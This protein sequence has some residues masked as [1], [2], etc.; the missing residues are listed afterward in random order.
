[1]IRRMSFGFDNLLGIDP[2]RPAE[3]VLKQLPAKWA[4]YL[5]ADADGRPVQ[6]LA[7]RNLRASVRRRVFEPPEGLSKRI[8]Y[9]AVVRQIHWKRVDSAMESDLAYL[10]AA[11]S[12]YPDTYRQIVS[13]RR[14]WFV[15]VDPQASFPRWK[16]IDAPPVGGQTFGPILERGQA[17]KLVETLEDLFDLCRYHNILVQSPKGAPCP[18][19]DMG[20]CPAPCD[21]SVSM[22]QYRAL[23]GWSA[24]TLADPKPEI[25]AQETRMRDAATELRFETAQKI[26]QFVTGLQSLRQTDWRFVRPLTDFRYLSLQT[27]PG[28]GLVKLFSVTPSEVRCVAC[29]RS[30]PKELMLRLDALREL[31]SPVPLA[32]LDAPALERLGLVVKHLFAVRGGVF[33]HAD[34]LTDRAILA[35]YR[36]LAKRPAP[37]EALD[38]EGVVAGTSV[39]GQGSGF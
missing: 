29:L 26:K 17:N 19:K 10:D 1:M 3:S 27:G 36:Q 31:Q 18:Y 23:V 24:R 2:Q 9:R 28:K 38:D 12:V 14:A 5:M 37:E 39:E 33:L 35:A 25:E 4:V 11:R 21:G 30:E 13:L 32:E 8:D 20:R 7:V 15:H 34:D 6:M 22:Q 16:S